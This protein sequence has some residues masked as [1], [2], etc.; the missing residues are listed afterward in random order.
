MLSLAEQA[1]QLINGESTAEEEM[2]YEQ[3]SQLE[4]ALLQVGYY[5]GTAL[6]F[7]ETV[8]IF[9]CPERLPFTMRSV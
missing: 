3:T 7:R 1:E 4:S 9:R 5:R 6:L 2:Y 8:R